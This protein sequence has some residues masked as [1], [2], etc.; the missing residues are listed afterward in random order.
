LFVMKKE[1]GDWKIASLRVLAPAP[2]GS[3]A[4]VAAP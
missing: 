2:H 4:A 1:G 3:T